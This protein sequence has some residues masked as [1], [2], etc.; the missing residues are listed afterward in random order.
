MFKRAKNINEVSRKREL[1]SVDIVKRL[2]VISPQ[3]V[4][5]KNYPIDNPVSIF[6][7]ALI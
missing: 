3:R 6:N 5:L 2:S 4:H 7:P 1:K